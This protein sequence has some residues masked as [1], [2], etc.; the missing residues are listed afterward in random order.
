MSFPQTNLCASVVRQGP[1]CSCIPVS[2]ATAVASL[3][4]ST[5]P[6]ELLVQLA[7]PLLPIAG[8]LSSSLAALS[9]WEDDRLDAR[10]PGGSGY[11]H[12]AGL[13]ASGKSFMPSRVGVSLAR[14]SD[15]AALELELSTAQTLAVVALAHFPA[16]PTR[17]PHSILV[18]HDPS[19][20]FFVRDSAQI[21]YQHVD[22]AGAS[23]REAIDSVS[24]LSGCIIGEAICL[25]LE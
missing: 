17:G 18:G 3:K 13:H 7:S 23:L 19:G 11:D 22:G 4:P 10:A 8:D 24:S 16:E 9:S 6:E 15:V 25:S 12:L 5:T 20:R 2:Y 14:V 21:D 1:T